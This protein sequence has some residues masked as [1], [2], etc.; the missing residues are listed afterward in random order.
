MHIYPQDFF[1]EDEK[2]K[3][4]LSELDNNEE[5]E[6]FHQTTTWMHPDVSD[7]EK[8]SDS[9]FFQQLALALETNDISMLQENTSN[10]DWKNWT[11]SDFENQ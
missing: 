4:L 6:L 9:A 11:W 7:E 10:T 2:C 1:L 3:Q 8:P 5:V